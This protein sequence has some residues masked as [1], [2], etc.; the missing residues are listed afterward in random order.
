MKCPECNGEMYGI[1]HKEDG[2]TGECVA[3]HM[4]CDVCGCEVKLEV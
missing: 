1:G 4:R 2:S 3:T